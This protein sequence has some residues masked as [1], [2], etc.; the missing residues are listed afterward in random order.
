LRDDNEYI[1]N[2]YTL[3]E[4]TSIKPSSS[5]AMERRDEKEEKEKI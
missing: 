3:D 1:H 4:T 2:D 5:A